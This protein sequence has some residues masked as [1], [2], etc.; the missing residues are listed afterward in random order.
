MAL[1]VADRVLETSTTTGTGA[2]TLAGA[3]VGYRAA[4]AVAANTDTLYYYAEEVDA[5]GVPSGGWETG[6]GTWGT[7][8]ILTRTTI[9]ASS[10]AGAAV[11][12]TAGTRRIALALTSTH[13]KT[14]AP[15]N[16]VV[17]ATTTATLTVNGDTTD[18]S[19]LSA[20]V[21]ALT[22]A[23]PTGTPVTTQPLLIEIKGDGG[24]IS[25][26]GL[27]TNRG[28]TK[29]ATA[30]SAK[31]IRIACEYNLAATTW[32]IVGVSTEA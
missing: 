3:V 29:P 22:I 19:I 23:N 32:D 28:A 13:L 14:F 18:V 20:Q 8:S 31:W 21:G 2:Y 7:G 27:F 26:G 9:H 6:L 4:S 10:N 17:T 11:S 15:N 25:Y 5:N 12:W 24:A 30:T 16:R 1:I